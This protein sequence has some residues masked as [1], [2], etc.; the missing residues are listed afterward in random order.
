MGTSFRL[1]KP[2]RRFSW[3]GVVKGAARTEK[4]HSLNAVEIRCSD[5]LKFFSIKQR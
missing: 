5:K 1:I 4:D 3:L 2:A